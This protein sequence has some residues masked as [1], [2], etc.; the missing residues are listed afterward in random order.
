VEELENE[1]DEDDDF[2]SLGP[3]TPMADA[4]SLDCFSQSYR[5]P[6]S[7]AGASIAP[8][9]MSSMSDNEEIFVHESEPGSSSEASL[10]KDASNSDSESDYS[11]E[12]SYDNEVADVHDL[13]NNLQKE[14]EKT[15]E[16]NEVSAQA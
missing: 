16:Q 3:V 12:S 10:R 4:E 14:R 2:K 13:E 15:Q 9:A 8:S 11:L 5:M 6:E 7:S 1:E